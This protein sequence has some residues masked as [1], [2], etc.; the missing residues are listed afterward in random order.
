MAAALFIEDECKS[1][2]I[3]MKYIPIHSHSDT[4]CAIILL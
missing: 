2:Y 1:L 3:F 4:N